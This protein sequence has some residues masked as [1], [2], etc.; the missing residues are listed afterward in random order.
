MPSWPPVANKGLWAGNQAMVRTGPK[1]P[2]M[3]ATSNFMSAVAPSSPFCQAA[4]RVA[5]P[6]RV[7]GEETRRVG[8]WGVASDGSVSAARSQSCTLPSALPT[9]RIPNG[10][11]GRQARHSASDL[12]AGASCI[13][14]ASRMRGGWSRAVRAAR[15]KASGM[16]KILTAPSAQATA[17]NPS[18]GSVPS[19]MPSHGMAAF[20]AGHQHKSSAPPPSWST[21]DCNRSGDAVRSPAPVATSHKLIS[22]SPLLSAWDAFIR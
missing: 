9:A 22:L 11:P 19:A 4:E 17:S 3:V 8:A 7:C 21:N 14:G 13:A 2:V 16:A 6:R 1:W 20:P 12:E 15:P 18:R 10:A 5:C